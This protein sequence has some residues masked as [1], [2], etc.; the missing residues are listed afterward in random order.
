[1]LSNC[2]FPHT[3]LRVDK[4]YTMSKVEVDTKVNGNIE[5]PVYAYAGNGLNS[6]HFDNYCIDML[7]KSGYNTNEFVT[8]DM[9]SQRMVFLLCL[10]GMCIRFQ[11]LIDSIYEQALKRYNESMYYIIEFDSIKD[12]EECL[13]HM[14]YKKRE[15]KYD[16]KRKKLYI[17]MR[18]DDGVVPFEFGSISMVPDIRYNVLKDISSI[19]TGA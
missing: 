12:T 7:T 10:P 2:F 4:P 15:V 18:D 3:G 11:E 19:V 17:K 5:L 16:D 9:S 8:V 6:E 13:R 1:M 14:T